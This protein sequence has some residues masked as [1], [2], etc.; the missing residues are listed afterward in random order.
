MNVIKGLSTKS[1][2]SAITEF[3]I[4]TLPFFTTFLILVSLVHQKSIAVS[5]SDN[6]ARQAVRAYV[7]SPNDQ[8]AQYR[9]NQVIS[10]YQSHLSELS[11]NSREIALKIS[12]QKYPCFT[13]G[14]LVTAT[15][16]VGEFQSASASEFV[17]LWR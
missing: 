7:T 13:P 17:D 14:N 15:I 4:F 1:T 10:I 3:L 8:L 6:L 12:C 5:E 11:R 16:K 2:G 9:A